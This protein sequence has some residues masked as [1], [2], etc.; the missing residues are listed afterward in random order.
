MVDHLKFF[1][2]TFQKYSYSQLK[3]IFQ[4]N[5]YD[6]VETYQYLSKYD[7]NWYLIIKLIMQL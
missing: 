7:V 5:Q 3:T 1:K 6:P 2:E 4:E